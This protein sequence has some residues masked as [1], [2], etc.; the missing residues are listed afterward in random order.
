MKL[1]F[2]YFNRATQLSP[3]QINQAFQLV[4]QFTQVKRQHQVRVESRLFHHQAIRRL[5]Q[6]DLHRKRYTSRRCALNLLPS[7]YIKLTLIYT[8][9]LFT[10]HFSANTNPKPT[11]FTESKPRAFKD[12]KCK[13]MSIFL[14]FVT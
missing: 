12:P 3:Q 1:T 7:L 14:T 8:I 2:A 13:L 10:N 4:L 6:L 5:F 9:N 11:S